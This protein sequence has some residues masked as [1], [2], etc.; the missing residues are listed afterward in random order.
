MIV[1]AINECARRPYPTKWAGLFEA[2]VDGRMVCAKSR[3]PFLAAARV[4]LSEG[5]D[6]ATVIVMRHAGSDLD[7]LKAKLGV[8]AKLAVD[9]D[10]PYFVHWKPDSRF[11]SAESR[12]IDGT[13]EGATQPAPAPE[14]PKNTHPLD[15]P[16][17]LEPAGAAW[18]LWT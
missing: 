17:P 9:D 7:C 12:I 6:P 14:T 2:R 15:C 16:S 3:T 8:A 18:R 13:G 4:L 11:P 1:V 10:G 5:H